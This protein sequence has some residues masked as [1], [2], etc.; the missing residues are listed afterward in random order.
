M[1]LPHKLAH[2][3]R[4]RSS[5]SPEPGCGRMP[6]RGTL[7]NALAGHRL[8][9]CSRLTAI[10]LEMSAEDCGVTVAIY[11]PPPAGAARTRS[12]VPARLGMGEQ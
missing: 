4:D 10:C 5:P 12:V 9:G 7:T 2:R 11:P 1:N 3:L 6:P 8:A